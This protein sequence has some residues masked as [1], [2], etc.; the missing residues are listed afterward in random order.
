MEEYEMTNTTHTEKLEIEQQLK[1]IY[2][3]SCSSNGTF[4]TILIGTQHVI[5][6]CISI[7]NEK[8]VIE[9]IPIF[10]SFSLQESHP[11]SCCLQN[12]NSCIIAFSNGNPIFT[13]LRLTDYLLIIKA[14]IASTNFNGKIW[15]N[16]DIMLSVNF[17][18][19]V[20]LKRTHKI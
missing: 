13:F 2:L 7:Q 19:S 9:I 12:L 10:Q 15:L 18:I 17:R 11:Y 3:S 8:I 4:V 16:H 6:F 20:A 14:S 5:F 1:Q